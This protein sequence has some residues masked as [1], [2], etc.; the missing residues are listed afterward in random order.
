MK[1]YQINH[2]NFEFK[3]FYTINRNLWLNEL[4]I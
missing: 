2:I 3:I 4:I 1:K